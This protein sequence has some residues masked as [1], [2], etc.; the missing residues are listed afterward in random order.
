MPSTWVIASHIEAKKEYFHQMKVPN[1][2]LFI[3]ITLSTTDQCCILESYK[4]AKPLTVLFCSCPT[5]EVSNIY[6]SAHTDIDFFSLSGW[7]ETL[8]NIIHYNLIFGAADTKLKLVTLALL[9]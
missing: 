3:Y 1:M 4:E 9:F 7:P 2:V 6:K 5:R 8:L